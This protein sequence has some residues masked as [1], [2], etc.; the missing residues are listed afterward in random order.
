MSRPLRI[1]KRHKKGREAV[2]KAQ[3]KKVGKGNNKHLL[4][5]GERRQN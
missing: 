5:H 2:L 4:R 1:T 3:A